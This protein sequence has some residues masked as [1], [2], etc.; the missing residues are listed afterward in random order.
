MNQTL[1]VSSF[2]SMGACDG[3]SLRSVIFLF[4]CPLRCDYCHNP[5]TWHTEKPEF[6]E[7]TIEN[8]VKK[9]LR[10]KPYYTNNGGVTVSGGEPLLQQDNIIPLFQGLHAEGV[11]CCIDS[12]A[13]VKIKSELL[14]LCD[15]LL[16]DIKFLSGQEYLQYTGLDIW[17]NLLYL[18]DQCKAT[19]TPIWIRHVL[20]PEVTDSEDYVQRLLDFC[21]NYDNIQRIDLLPFKN[22]CTSK[23]ETLN[24]PFKMKDT[25]LTAQSQVDKLKQ[26]VADYS[27]QYLNP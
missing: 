14:D 3:P 19:K 26:M 18:L 24:L 7:E 27:E 13:G 22:I 6:Q 17:D 16:V 23:Y 1:K 25:P 12:S 5:E 11:H 4:G 20:Y 9:V 15:L 2:L 8:L 10:Y 21:K